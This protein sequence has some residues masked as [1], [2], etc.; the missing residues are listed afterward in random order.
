MNDKLVYTIPSGIIKTKI[1]GFDFEFQGG[2]SVDYVKL[3]N[4]TGT[5]KYDEEF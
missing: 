4:S 1:Y 2:G 3:S 5:V